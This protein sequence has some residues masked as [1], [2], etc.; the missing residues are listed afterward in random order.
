ML[1]KPEGKDSQAVESYFI[2]VTDLPEFVFVTS[3]LLTLILRRRLPLFA[4]G[5]N[6]QPIHCNSPCLKNRAQIHF[7]LLSSVVFKSSFQ[8]NSNKVNHLLGYDAS[9]SIYSSMVFYVGRQTTLPMFIIM[10]EH[11]IKCNAVDHW[12]VLN[13]FWSSMAQRNVIYDALAKQAAFVSIINSVLVL[14]FVRDLL[15]MM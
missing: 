8:Y 2:T 7:Y 6:L 11:G 12:C 9:V 3:L 10:R 4:C 15:T 14:V 5:S 1:Q 13:S